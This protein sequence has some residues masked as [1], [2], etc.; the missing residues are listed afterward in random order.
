MRRGSGHDKRRATGEGEK[1]G[2]NQGERKDGNGTR[3][4]GRVV[5]GLQ[6]APPPLSSA[7]QSLTLTNQ[8]IIASN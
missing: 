3:L 4:G 5:F 2:N 7:L 1:K 8:S 6:V